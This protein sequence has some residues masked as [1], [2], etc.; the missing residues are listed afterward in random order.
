MFT[1]PHPIPIPASSS[2][3]YTNGHTELKVDTNT[4]HSKP[5]YA[6]PTINQYPSLFFKSIRVV[7]SPLS[8]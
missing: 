5:I 7:S 1:H 2:S 4:G 8:N 6:T 3:S